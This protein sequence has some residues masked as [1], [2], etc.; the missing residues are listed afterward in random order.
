[1]FLKKSRKLR[2]RDIGKLNDENTRN[3]K[4]IIIIMF[5]LSNWR[6]HLVTAELIFT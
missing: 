5:H 2:R 4:T 1:M 6:C 3:E